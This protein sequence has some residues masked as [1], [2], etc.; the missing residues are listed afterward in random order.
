MNPV[1][2][3]VLPCAW[4]WD[5]PELEENAASAKKNLRGNKY[6]EDIVRM[7]GVR[8][9]KSMRKNSKTGSLCLRAVGKMNVQSVKQKGN[10]V[11]EKKAEK[12][13]VNGGG[14]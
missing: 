6:Q 7:A 1:V 5:I 4:H 11:E 14:K 13:G 8:E 9:A 2:P 12:Q 10:Q 3:V